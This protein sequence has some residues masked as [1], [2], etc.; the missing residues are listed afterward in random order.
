MKTEMNPSFSRVAFTHF[1][2]CFFA[3][4]LTLYVMDAILPRTVIIN[5]T[6]NMFTLGDAIMGLAAGSLVATLA[7]GYH[8]L[9]NRRLKRIG[10]RSR[11]PSPPRAIVLAGIVGFICGAM[12]V[13]LVLHSE[14]IIAMTLLVLVV[15][16]LHLRDFARR[17]TTMLHPGNVASWGDVSE[18]LRIYATMLA[19]FTM[20]NATMEGAHLLA[21]APAPFGFGVEGGDI[22]LNSLYYTVVTMTTLG[23]GDIVPRTWDAK[24]LLIIQCLISYFMFALVIGII[25]RGVVRGRKE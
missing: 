18:L 21:G 22:F 6:D 25:T 19:G 14:G 4:M 23:F 15:L 12:D 5:L 3:G 10:A 11:Q 8:M 2:P 9:R 1:V 13:L 17:M 20:V 16:G 24:F 7:S